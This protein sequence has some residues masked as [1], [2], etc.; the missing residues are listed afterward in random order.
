M[1]VNEVIMR[2]LAMDSWEPERRPLLDRLSTEVI[3]TL[4]TGHS[5]GINL[6]WIQTF[7][8]FILWAVWRGTPHWWEFPIILLAAGLLWGSSLLRDYR[9]AVGYSRELENRVLREER[10]FGEQATR[11]N[12]D[13][14]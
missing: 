11:R 1:L 10:N 6:V 7:L 2:T 12:E 13:F 3:A 9:D 4:S 5:I 8:L 14:Y